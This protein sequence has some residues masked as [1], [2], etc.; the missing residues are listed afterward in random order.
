MQEIEAPVANGQMVHL[1]R[2][3][4]A[5]PNGGQFAIT[6]ECTIKQNNVGFVNGI[7]QFVR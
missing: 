1:S 7:L 2:T 6:P 4:G 3:T 5:W